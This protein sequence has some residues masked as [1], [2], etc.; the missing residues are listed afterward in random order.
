MNTI[1][2]AKAA[3]TGARHRRMAR[4]GQDAAV[5]WSEGDV[6]VAGR[7]VLAG[8]PLVRHWQRWFLGTSPSTCS[9]WAPH[10]AQL[11]R[12]QALHVVRLHIPH[13]V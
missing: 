4:N 7:L 9:T 3:V 8:A 12:P 11:G 10:P 1:S 5:S 6:A 13:R 2:I